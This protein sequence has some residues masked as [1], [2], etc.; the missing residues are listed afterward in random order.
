[1]VVI[2]GELELFLPSSRSL[3]DKRQVL[4][5]LK[6]R[7]RNRFEIAVAEVDHQDQWQRARLGIVTVS[8]SAQRAEEVLDRALRYVEEDLR[9]QVVDR[10][11][12]ER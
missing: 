2:S 6:D 8:A 5:S 3:K 9:V 7:L 10:L 1:V 11:V 4:A 12:E